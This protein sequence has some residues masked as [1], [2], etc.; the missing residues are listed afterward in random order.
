MLAIGRSVAVV[1]LVV[2]AL[3]KPSFADRA[4][5]FERDVQPILAAKCFGC[6]AGPQAQGQL[7]LQTGKSL[8][9]GSKNGP[10]VTRG[11]AAQSK[12]FQKIEAHQMPPP[13][14][15]RL[16]DEEI[17]LIGEWIDGGAQVSEAENEA[18]KPL[19]QA[20]AAVAKP[21]SGGAPP[22]YEQDVQT[23]FMKHCVA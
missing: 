5:I 22:S 11:S 14:A 10:V 18:A 20:T 2:I 17:R 7:D 16:T 12:L 8:F 13:G 3:G 15:G 23:I 4:A 1:T 19:A 9:R 21:V 6:H